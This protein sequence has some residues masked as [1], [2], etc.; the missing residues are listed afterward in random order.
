MISKTLG[1]YFGNIMLFLY[2]ELGTLLIVSIAYSTVLMGHIS[3]EETKLIMNIALLIPV[4]VWLL[5][6]AVE[7]N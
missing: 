4:V 6:E 1:K 2:V 3:D 7:V 5:W